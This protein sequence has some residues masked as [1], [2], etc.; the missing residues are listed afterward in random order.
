MLI[1]YNRS[2]ESGGSI[3]LEEIHYSP[4]SEDGSV[5]STAQPLADFFS[6][7]AEGL[8]A[9]RVDLHAVTLLAEKMRAAGFINV[10]TNISYIPISR[11]D[12]QSKAENDAATC[13]RSTIYCG[14]QGTALGP[15]TRGLGWGSQE[16]EGYLVEVRD[17]LRSGLQD[18][19][20][21]MY[22]IHAQRP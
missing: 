18:T 9:L 19:K 16:V 10:T 3:E 7:I 8:K 13:M 4:Q 1:I 22:I 17:C 15:L 21:P 14:L 5:H 11:N 6:K 2:L 20:L 12:T